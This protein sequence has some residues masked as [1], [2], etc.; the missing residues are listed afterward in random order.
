MKVGETTF[1]F[2]SEV[3]ADVLKELFNYKKKKNYFT[4]GV[5]YGNG[6]IQ[7]IGEF[8]LLPA[9]VIKFRR[10]KKGKRYIISK[11]ELDNNL[12][13]IKNMEYKVKE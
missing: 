10:K 8:G 13:F 3:N 7:S 2:D 5:D 9:K 11:Y 12:C 1:S 6:D 4:L